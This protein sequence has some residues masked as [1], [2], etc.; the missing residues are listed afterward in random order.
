MP[1]KPVRFTLSEDWWA[2]IAAF[3]LI[4][5]VAVARAVGLTLPIKF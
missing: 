4:A 3:I 2:V 5:L 1:N